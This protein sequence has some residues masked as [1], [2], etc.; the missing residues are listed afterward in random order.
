MS[1]L[2]LVPSIF[3]PPKAP[4]TPVP[5]SA[6][7]LVLTQGEHCRAVLASS[8][9]T[10]RALSV[11][12]WNRREGL[13]R[14]AWLPLFCF[15]EIIFF[16]ER[17]AGVPSYGEEAQ[18][19]QSL[20]PAGNPWVW[21]YDHFSSFIFAEAMHL[22]LNLA[23]PFKSHRSTSKKLALLDQNRWR[24][25]TWPSAVW[26][27]RTNHSGRQLLLDRNQKITKWISSIPS[28]INS[29]ANAFLL[30]AEKSLLDFYPQTCLQAQT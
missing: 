18:A 28:F 5:S 17:Q 24:V 4:E 29:M 26:A 7:P 22:W 20:Q 9:A 10:A 15:P 1:A 14:F 11:V 21:H 30:S 3:P 23:Q 19:R 2:M 25:W 8:A 16:W 13:R 27:L 12:Q 6:S